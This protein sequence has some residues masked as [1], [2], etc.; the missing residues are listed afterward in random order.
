MADARRGMQN[1]RRKRGARQRGG[2]AA[3]EVQGARIRDSAAQCRYVRARCAMGKGEAALRARA[4]CVQQCAPPEAEGCVPQAVEKC[5]A[6]V[7]AVEVWA[8]A[9]RRYRRACV[10][11]ARQRCTG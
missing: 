7:V 3:K 1:I 11:R 9:A 10:A 4:R 2:G 8:G 5:G 6:S